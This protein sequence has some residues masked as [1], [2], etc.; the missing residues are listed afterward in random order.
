MELYFPSLIVL[1]LAAI[2]VFFI[3]PRFAP[4]VLAIIAFIA[5]ILGVK[6]N[7]QM[8]APD[9]R[10]MTWQEG[11]SS[12]APYILVGFS[13]LYIL[14]FLFGIYRN[15]KPAVNQAV[16]QTTQ[17]M[18]SFAPRLAE[19]PRIAAPANYQQKQ[20]NLSPLF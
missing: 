11:V 14:G 8:F 17:A 1:I 19:A 10:Q 5:L 6:Q 4:I 20:K 18:N 16:T 2:V 7:L 12:F 9:Y 13:I 3:F 15:K